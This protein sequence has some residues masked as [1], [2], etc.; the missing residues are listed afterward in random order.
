MAEN[1]SAGTPS[2]AA[3]VD[4]EIHLDPESRRAALEDE[5]R[6]GLTASPRQLSPVWFYDETGSRLFDRITRLPEYYPTRAEQQILSDHAEEIVAIARADTLVELGSGTSEKT[7]TLLDAMA[8]SGRL[9]AFVPLDVSEEVLVEASTAIADEYGIDVGPIVGDFVAHLDVVPRVG[10]RLIVFLGS[11]IGNLDHLARRRF[12]FD[13]EAA[14]ERTDSFL[15]GT[16]LVK[17]TDRLVAAYDDAAGVTAAFNRN[18]LA[19][20]NAELGGDFDPDAFDHVARWNAD[21]RWME[22]HLRANRDHR[23]RLADLDLD[24]SFAEG[25]EIRT[26]T[27]AKF[28][29]VDLHT[30]MEQM[31]FVVD[32]SWTD[33]AGDYLLTL[34]HPYC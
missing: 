32:K 17:D 22:M 23:V 16:D 15:L 29:L 14:M 1:P 2:I 13:L 11:T 3:G 20:L 28:E 10:E 21:E 34:A 7:R 6:A 5:V 30:E 9:D 31:G 25:D 33:P 8:G 12:L 4:V 27:S 19:V 24:L 26:E 18:V